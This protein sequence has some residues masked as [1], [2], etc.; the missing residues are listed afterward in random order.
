M[1][2]PAADSGAVSVVSSAADCTVNGRGQRG[3]QPNYMAV[4]VCFRFTSSDDHQW[5][6][7]P[8]ACCLCP[9]RCL[10]GSA[11]AAGAASFVV[12]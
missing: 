12:H 1:Q 5:L 7:S 9:L 11:A 2:C 8:G 3:L 10:L 4:A 6:T